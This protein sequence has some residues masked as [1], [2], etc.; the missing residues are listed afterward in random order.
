VGARRHGHYNRWDPTAGTREGIEEQ[1][2]MGKA[3]GDASSG[4]TCRALDATFDSLLPALGAVGLQAVPVADKLVASPLGNQAE[5]QGGSLACVASKARVSAM[6]WVGAGVV[7][8]FGGHDRIPKY[9]QDMVAFID[10]TGVDGVLM[11]VL[12]SDDTLGPE[13]TTLLLFVKRPGGFV[14]V[15]WEGHMQEKR[16]RFEPVVSKPKSEDERIQNIGRVY[17]HTF[18]LMAAKLV[19]DSRK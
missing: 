5:N 8:A 1:V 11:A 15:A 14:D 12:G 18:E 3:I 2:A 7:A 6:S 10:E 16:I 19:S 9:Q 17:H 13:A 4:V